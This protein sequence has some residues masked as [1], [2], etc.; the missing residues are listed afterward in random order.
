MHPTWLKSLLMSLSLKHPHLLS[1]RSHL[2]V[3]QTQSHW[4]NQMISSLMSIPSLL[5]QPRLAWTHYLWVALLMA[6]P[7]SASGFWD[8]R[9]EQ[10]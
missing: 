6:F 9:C 10:S 4:R 7:V 2:S 8:Y 3:V 1:N 5:L